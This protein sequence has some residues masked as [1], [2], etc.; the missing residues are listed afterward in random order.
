MKDPEPSNEPHPALEG[1]L[2]ESLGHDGRVREEF[3]G[4]VMSQIDGELEAEADRIIRINWR[5]T[6][7]AAAASLVL[8]LFIFLSSTPPKA[9]AV[10]NIRDVR[11]QAY[12]IRAAGGERLTLA[13]GMDVF[14]GDQ[15]ICG[16]GGSVTSDH[17]DGTVV[18]LSEG[19]L[20]VGGDGRVKGAIELQT[21]RALCSL[22]KGQGGFRTLAFSTPHAAGEGADSTVE[23]VVTAEH[24]RVRA[25]SGDVRVWNRGNANDW[26]PVT[27]G[28]SATLRT[29]APLQAKTFD[30]DK[31]EPG[32][33]VWAQE[34]DAYFKTGANIEGVLVTQRED[35]RLTTIIQSIPVDPWYQ[36]DAFKP[37]E[38]ISLELYS[39]R[40]LFVIPDDMEMVLRV[41][42]RKSGIIRVAMPMADPEFKTEHVITDAVPI[43]PAWQRLVLPAQAFMA[44]RE[45]RAAEKGIPVR[46]VAIWGERTGTIDLDRVLV[47]RRR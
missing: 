14:V 20:L 15:L 32:D 24:T 30:I 9:T 45:S 12:L 13:Q 23:L 46:S 34:F 35:Q 31:I 17:A 41:R 6:G 22:A 10:A 36:E 42:S 43:G 47:R 19:R 37:D 38:W 33:V 7:L 16:N 44:F 39:R 3:V 25:L 21:G 5:G 28:S 29:G 11:G 26:A 1:I 4:R 18:D 8:G 40:A 2:R 27:A